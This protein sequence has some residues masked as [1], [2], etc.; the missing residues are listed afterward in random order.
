MVKYPSTLLLD[1]HNSLP[2]QYL[3]IIAI[4]DCEMIIFR[5]LDYYQ[6]ELNDRIFSQPIERLQ[7]SIK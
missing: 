1:I 7:G 3:T 6:I 2:P 4:T 5:N